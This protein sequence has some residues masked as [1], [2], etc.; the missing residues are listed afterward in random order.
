MFK[1]LVILSV[2]TLIQGCRVIEQKA[3]GVQQHRDSHVSH[4]LLETFVTFEQ[5]YLCSGVLVS[6][7]FVL[8]TINCVFGWTFVNVHLYPFK[9]RD[10]FEN[11]REIYRSTEVHFKPGFDLTQHLNDVALVKL[12][13]T[14]NVAG[15]FYAIA[16]LPFTTDRLVPDREGKTVGWGLLNFKDDN[17]AEYK[18]EQTMKVVSDEVCRQAYPL[19]W[20]DEASFEGRV[21]IQRNFGVNCVSDTGSPFYIGDVVYGLQSFGQREACD[22]AYPNGIQEVRHHLTWINSII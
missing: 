10:V 20:S 9:L 12:P 13:V 22:D 15:R 3:N 11:S 8:T 4:V 16:Q 21:C 19:W 18:H 2:L 5:K 7:N 14:L 1:L 6:A 17:A